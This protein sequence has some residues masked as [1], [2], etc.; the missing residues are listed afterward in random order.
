M[1]REAHVALQ[2]AEWRERNS[3]GAFWKELDFVASDMALEIIG[4]FTLVGL[5]D[6]TW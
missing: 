3:R 6:L 1:T 2:A 5:V 4:D